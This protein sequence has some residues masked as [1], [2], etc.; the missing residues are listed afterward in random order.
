MKYYFMYKTT[1]NINGKFYVG[2]HSTLKLDDGYLGSGVKIQRAIKK[3]G[4]QNFSREILE[5]YSN[6]KEMLFAESIMVNEDFIERSDTYNVIVG[7]GHLNINCF[8]VIDKDG[9]KFL[10]NKKDEKVLSGEYI[11]NTKNKIS[12]KDEFG[13]TFQVEKGHPDYISGKLV[14][15]AKGTATVKDEFGNRTRIKTDH[16][17][18]I[19][20]K[21]VGATKDYVVRED[22]KEKLKIANTGKTRSYETKKLMSEKASLRKNETASTY[23]TCWMYNDTLQKCK[24]IKKIDT[25]EFLNSGWLLGR[26]KFK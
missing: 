12:V 11:A 18:Y 7:G 6:E 21:F 15:V 17:D 22:T 2:V 16:P 24:M 1:N 25:N 4:K 23:N 8:C 9:N 5:F 19:S 10:A 13:N 3:Y 14:G 26:K 20:G